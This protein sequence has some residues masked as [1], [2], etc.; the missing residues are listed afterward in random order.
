MRLP[1]TR[2]LLYFAALAEHRHFGKAAA[3]SFVSQSA[4][5]V[6]IRELETLLG[7]GLV[8]RTNRRG[9]ASGTSR[10]SWRLPRPSFPRWPAHCALA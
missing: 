1:S 10:L 6:A 3:V 2:Q 7:V 5:S 9:C 4:F 8:D